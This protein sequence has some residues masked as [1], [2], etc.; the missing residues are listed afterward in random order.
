VT[1][2]QDVDV[3]VVGAGLSGIGA[4]YR[5][6]T[7]LPHQ[8]FLVLEGRASTGGTWD[9]FRYPGIRSDSDMFTL[10]FAF[11]PWGSERAI[12]EGGAI[13]K[14]LRDTVTDLGLEANI[15][16]GHRVKEARWSSRDARWTLEVEV[17]GQT[18][19]FRCRFLYLCSGYYDYAQAHAPRF[20]GQERYRGRVI[21]PQWWP[22][23]VDCAGEKV[24]VIGSGAT[25]VTLVPALARTA[26]KVTMLQRSPTWII[27]LPNRDAIARVLH[28]MLPAQLA[29]RLVRAKNTFS[30]LAFY[31]FCRWQPERAGK[32]LL[33]ELT[34]KLP[35][36]Y[37]VER[38]FK[39]R[40]NP[41]EQRLCLVPDDDLFEAISDGKASVVT[42]TI[43]HFTE[44]GIQLSSGEHL[45]ADTIVT[46][47]GLKLLPGGGI[48]VFVDGE[49]LQLHDHV[50]YRNV[51]LD[52]VPNLAWCIGYTNSSWT[53]RADLCSRWVCRLLKHMELGGH[54]TVVPRARGLG[55][56]RRPMFD[57]HAGYIDRSLG[58]LPMQGTESPWYLRQNYLVDFFTTH[59]EPIDDGT[60]EFSITS[61]AAATPRSPAP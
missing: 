17:A 48:R 26:A 35:A 61:A 4:A 40:Y 31:L 55:P 16:T 20:E 29:H 27:S 51:M 11:R 34:R 32:F 54:A 45:E 2:E 38:H 5:L 19:Q 59:F 1:P 18:H 9:L 3:I 56:G 13:L 46:A 8:R 41:W 12:A 52:D 7:M 14:Y 58:V 36:G 43:S 30:H 10:G 57:L 50:A 49:A 22:E 25:A 37:P 28:A 42:E 24:V 39:P 44:R 21:H 60:L 33:R 53:L 47:T 6:K 15:R 23:G